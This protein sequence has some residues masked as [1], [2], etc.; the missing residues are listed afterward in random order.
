[1]KRG[2]G[3]PPKTEREQ[4]GQLLWLERMLEEETTALRQ[5]GH[6]GHKPSKALARAAARLEISERSAWRLVAQLEQQNDSFTA[7][8]TSFGDLL[9]ELG[10]DGAKKDNGTDFLAVDSCSAG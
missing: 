1:M 2:R 4:F 10:L 5:Q 8:I 3:R 9:R 6:K 7:S